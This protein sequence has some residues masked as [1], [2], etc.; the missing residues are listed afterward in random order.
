MSTVDLE[1]LNKKLTKELDN[2]E[3]HD[4][5]EA[6]AKSFCFF[7]DSLAVHKLRRT[8]WETAI[9]GAL[10][11][12]VL[13]A[14]CLL[15]GSGPGFALGLIIVHQVLRTLVLWRNVR[16]SEQEIVT[17]EQQVIVLARE[18][19]SVHPLDTARAA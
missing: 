18:L 2:I 16:K 7:R 15:I 10:T 9:R 3:W 12:I 13:A 17:L 11:S 19:V 1:R 6:D 8:A 4:V 5:P 14:I